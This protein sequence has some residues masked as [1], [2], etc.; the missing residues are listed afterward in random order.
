MYVFLLYV[1]HAAEDGR[2]P[3]YVTRQLNRRGVLVVRGVVPMDTALQW[4]D[5][6]MV[7][8][9]CFSAC[10]VEVVVVIVRWGCTT[11]CRASPDQGGSFFSCLVFQC[12]CFSSIFRVTRFAVD[13]VCEI[14]Y[15]SAWFAVSHVRTCRFCKRQS[16]SRLSSFDF[17]ARM[18][19]SGG[20]SRSLVN[21]KINILGTN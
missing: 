6:L 17:I 10:R 2:F 16:C 3:Y 9:D 19:M 8:R 12:C 21:I 4:R 18:V 11:H 15:F 20:V 14:F 5:D 1:R 13:H 7:R